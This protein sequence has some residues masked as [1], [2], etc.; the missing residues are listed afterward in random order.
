M[1]NI[2][3]VGENVPRATLDMIRHN[4]LPAVNM[5]IV[6]CTPGIRHPPF[7]LRTSLMMGEAFMMFEHGFP[8][9]IYI[10]SLFL[11]IDRLSIDS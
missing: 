11:S 3:E 5:A 10:H 6:L 1:F 2:R 4:R 9:V 7:H 8:Y